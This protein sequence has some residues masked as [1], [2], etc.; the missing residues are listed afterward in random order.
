LDDAI[1]ATGYDGRVIVGSWYGEKPAMLDLGTSFHRDRISLES[2]QV[3]TLAPESRG[4]WTRSRRA[5]TAVNRLRD[6]DV[7]SLV[8]HRFPFSEAPEAYRL[9]D[10]RDDDVLQVLL[11][12]S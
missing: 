5:E 9:L 8:T 6:L 4:R 10:E 2:S 3:S 12:Y 7:G 1:G 11:T